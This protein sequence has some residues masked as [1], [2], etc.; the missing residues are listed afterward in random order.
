MKN[1]LFAFYLIPC[2]TFGQKFRYNSAD[3]L[4]EKITTSFYVSEKLVYFDSSYVKNMGGGIHQFKIGK[5]CEQFGCDGTFSATGK[6]QVGWWLIENKII[7]CYLTPV[8]SEKMFHSELK[9]WRYNAKS[10]RFIIIL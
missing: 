7:I 1:L 5:V 10:G 9:I 3:T 8:S 6:I 2:L 4:V